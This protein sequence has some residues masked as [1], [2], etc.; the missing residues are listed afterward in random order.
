MIM[1]VVKR[2]L[3]VKSLPHQV[4]PHV[5]TVDVVNKKSMVLP[6]SYVLPVPLLLLLATVN[7]AH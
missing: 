5:I 1:A 2:V 7:C 6:V 4:L 3:Q